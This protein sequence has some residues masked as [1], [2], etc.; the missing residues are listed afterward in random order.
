MEAQ[1]G[2]LPWEPLMQLI[3]HKDNTGL[4]QKFVRVL[5]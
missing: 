4:T 5:P 3:T 2:S 1:I